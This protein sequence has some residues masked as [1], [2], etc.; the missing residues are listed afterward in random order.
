VGGIP[1]VVEHGRTGL[2]VKPGDPAALAAAIDAVLGDPEVARRMGAA[3]RERA[4]E[5]DWE[6]VADEV[7]ALYDEVLAA[8]RAE[9]CAS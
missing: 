6:R 5:Y 3:A 2:L 1:E 7:R 9:A 4:P 8:R